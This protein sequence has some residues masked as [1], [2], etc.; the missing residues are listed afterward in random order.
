MECSPNDDSLMFVVS[1]VERKSQRERARE[2][3]SRSP[4]VCGVKESEW[5]AN[6][7]IV[8]EIE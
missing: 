4:F 7:S 6:E 8:M 3:L 2:T 5:E 1:S